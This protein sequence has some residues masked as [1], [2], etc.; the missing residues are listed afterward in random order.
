MERP[1]AWKRGHYHR[2]TGS[3]QGV[4][5]V[6]EACRAPPIPG[7]QKSVSGPFQKKQPSFQPIGD[8]LVHYAKNSAK[9]FENA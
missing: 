8:A 2:Y 3:G 1:S 6:A 4:W 7:G 5:I 9:R